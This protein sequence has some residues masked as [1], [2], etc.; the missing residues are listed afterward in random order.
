MVDVRGLNVGVGKIRPD[1]H[2]VLGAHGVAL[3]HDVSVRNMRRHEVVEFLSFLLFLLETAVV[4]VIV[5]PPIVAV[6]AAVVV[7]FVA[8]AVDISAG[9]PVERAL[10]RGVWSVAWCVF[11]MSRKGHYKIVF[12]KTCAYD[13]PN[14]PCHAS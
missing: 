11:Y 9:G 13:F 6:V 3:E 14:R 4:P 10:V 1:S 2:L 7:P 8:A 12:T 5:T